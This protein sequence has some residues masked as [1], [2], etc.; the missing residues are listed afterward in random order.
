MR[1]D[2]VLSNHTHCTDNDCGF[3]YV[4][5]VTEGGKDTEDCSGMMLILLHWKLGDSRA[6]CCDVVAGQERSR[7]PVRAQSAR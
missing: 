5:D 6:P 4:A 1:G 3:E 7:L 2:W